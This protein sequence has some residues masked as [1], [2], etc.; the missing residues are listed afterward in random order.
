MSKQEVI[1]CH[2][3][4]ENLNKAITQC[5]HDKL[6]VLVDEHTC[7]LCI[8][9]LSGFDCIKNAH[10]ICIGAEDVHKNLETLANVWKELGDKDASR[11]SLLINL[12]GGMVTDLGGFAASTFKRGIK[13]INIPT[14]LLAMVDASVGGK[15]GINFNGLKN[16]IGVFSPA[17]SVLIDADFLKSLDLRN[18]LSGYAEMLKHG[19]ISTHDHWAELL[20]FDFNNIDYKVLQTLVGKSVQIKENI[21]EQIIRPTGLLDPEIEVRPVVNQVDDLIEQIHKRVLKKER[22]LVTTLTKK[23]AEDLTSYLASLAIKVRSM[24]SEIKALERMEIIRDLRIGEFDVLVGINLL[25]EGLDI[26]EVSLVAILDADK[27]GFLRSETSLIQ[28]IGRAA[29]N[30]EGKVIM[31]ADKITRSMES[32]ITETKRRR[33]IQMLYNEEHNI[34]PTTIKKKV[35]DAIEATVVADEETIYGIKETNNIDEIK[36]NIAALQA[37]MMEAAQNLQF[38]RAAELRDKIKQLEERINN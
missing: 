13:Y 31:Y 38:E 20:R 17:E 12:G 25:R 35:R 36:E 30:S 1:I 8:P 9:V 26:P 23:M 7:E 2:N 18:L 37:E 16:E 4:E 6:F 27:E 33:E 3:L 24:H 10:F 29:R 32:A 21:V 11:H 15:T 19:L 22:V 14:T 28:T 5:P 34:T